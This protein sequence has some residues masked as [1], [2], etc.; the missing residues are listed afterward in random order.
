MNNI[1]MNWKN[2]MVSIV[3]KVDKKVGNKIHTFA[4]V[5]EYGGVTKT[6]FIGSRVLAPTFNN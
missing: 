1:V 5:R 2:Q 4:K 6:I 3:G